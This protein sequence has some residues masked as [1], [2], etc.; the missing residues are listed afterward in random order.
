MQGVLEKEQKLKEK[1][2]SRNNEN[3]LI[4]AKLQ[5]TKYKINNMEK[6]SKDLENIRVEMDSL[7]AIL[8]EIDANYQNLK[9]KKHTL[10]VEH[11]NIQRDYK[12]MEQTLLK[13]QELEELRVDIGNEYQV[14]NEV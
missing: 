8:K 6:H 9:A 11:N 13:Q 14:K 5:A 12:N 4:L 1:L 2:Q 7:H 3:S 10:N